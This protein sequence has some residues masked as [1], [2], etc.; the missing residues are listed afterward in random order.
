MYFVFST[1]MNSQIDSLIN[2]K[3]DEIKSPIAIGTL[4]LIFDSRTKNNIK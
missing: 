1:I 4:N 2:W 3:V